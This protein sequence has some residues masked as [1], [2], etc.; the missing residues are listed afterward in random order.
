MREVLKDSKSKRGMI[1]GGEAEGA[2]ESDT[3]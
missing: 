1:T 3:F 2:T